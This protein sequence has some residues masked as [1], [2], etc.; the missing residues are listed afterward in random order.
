MRRFNEPSI[1]LPIITDSLI[2]ESQDVLPSLDAK[3]VDQERIRLARNSLSTDPLQTLEE[4]RA[5]FKSVGPHSSLYCLAGDAYVRLK[6]FA[7][8]ESSFYSALLLGS[9]DPSILLNLANL[10]HM[11]GDQMLAYSFLEMCSKKTPDFKHLESVRQSL[12]SQGKPIFSTSPVYATKYPRMV[13][14]KDKYSLRK[15]WPF[16]DQEPVYHTLC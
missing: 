3:D 1:H 12:F 13:I 2:Q 16:H 4:C 7:D 10:V 6:L 9:N 8:A 14:S 15:D 5:L 11:R